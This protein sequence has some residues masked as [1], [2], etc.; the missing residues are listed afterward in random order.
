MVCASPINNRQSLGLS[1]VAADKIAV[2]VAV[3]A[4][5]ASVVSVS[6]PSPLAAS[7]SHTS[8]CR[9]YL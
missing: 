4:V 5:A 8:A 3:A 7:T 9:D 1:A 6:A 2:A